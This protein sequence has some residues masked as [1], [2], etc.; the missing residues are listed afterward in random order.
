M[1]PDILVKEEFH[2]SKESI[3]TNVA[4]NVNYTSLTNT[5]PTANGIVQP[6]S[7]VTKPVGQSVVPNVVS[8][9]GFVNTNVV[10]PQATQVPINSVTTNNVNMNNSVNPFVNKVN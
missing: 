8:N 10:R 5:H 7:P 9:N 2:E 1:E 3:N 6:V 4:S